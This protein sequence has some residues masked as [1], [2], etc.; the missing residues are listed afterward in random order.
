MSLV[1]L[2]TKKLL[3]AQP[4]WA[5]IITACAQLSEEDGVFWGKAAL[6]RAQQWDRALVRLRTLG[7]LERIDKGTRNNHTASYRMPDRESVKQALAEIGVDLDVR[8]PGDFFDLHNRKK[9]ANRLAGHSNP[10]TSQI[11]DRRRRRVTRNVV[12][13][14]SI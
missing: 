5:P 10:R 13:R 11:Y 1:Y 8:L 3:Q 2:A 12:E 14:I 7:I 9:A 6:N 4:D